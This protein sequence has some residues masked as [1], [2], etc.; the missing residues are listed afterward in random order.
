VDDG[1]FGEL[2]SSTHHQIYWFA[3]RRLGH[4]QAKEVVSATFEVAWRSRSEFPEDPSFWRAWVV[5]IAKNKVLQEAQRTKRKHHDNR[6]VADW[7]PAGHEATTEDAA[8]VV[9]EHDQAMRVY[10][11][12]SPSE[13]LLFDVAFFRD[14]GPE[15]AARVL[16][17]STTALTSRVSRLRTRLKVLH[18]SEAGS[19]DESDA[20]EVV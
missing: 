17:I 16:G 5:G 20:G 2:Y 12:L 8:R 7:L 18:D 11:Q 13:Q 14:L 9:V 19:R 4:D 15:G 1:E 6:F 10:A 3:V